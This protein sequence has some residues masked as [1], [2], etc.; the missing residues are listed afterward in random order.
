MRRNPGDRVKELREALNLSQA[1]LCRR[2]GVG[3]ST[4]Y[5][6]EVAGRLTKR[7]AEKI[8][9]ILGIAVEDL[10][11]EPHGAGGRP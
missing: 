10:I 2:S 7:S 9:P 6:I 4:I 1:G 3:L 5:R 8:A 11:P